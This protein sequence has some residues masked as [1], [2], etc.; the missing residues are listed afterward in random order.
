MTITLVKFY[1][2]DTSADY[3]DGLH[4]I[5]RQDIIDDAMWGSLYNG[6]SITVPITDILPCYR[7][8]IIE[9]VF[10]SEYYYY[11]VF[12]TVLTVTNTEEKTIPT[13]IEVQEVHL[14]DGG[15]RHNFGFYLATKDEA[16]KY[17]K[18]DPHCYIS[19]RT[20]M[21]F[22]TVDEQQRFSQGEVKNRALSKLTKEER[23]ALG[24]PPT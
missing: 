18:L 20:L 19:P 22:N 4:N 15:D 3:D 7:K 24:F 6:E 8:D 10:N 16:D 5:F 2:K 21:I 23:I 13:I 1:L 14:W 11:E 12:G 9:G 17:K